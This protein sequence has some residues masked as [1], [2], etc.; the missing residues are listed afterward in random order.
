MTRNNVCSWVMVR[1][2]MESHSFFICFFKKKTKNTELQANCARNVQQNSGEGRA[3]MVKFL[4]VIPAK[5]R[6][7]LMYIA[8]YVNEDSWIAKE[9]ES[10]P[11]PAN[12]TEQGRRNYAVINS[13]RLVKSWKLQQAVKSHAAQV[14]RWQQDPNKPCFPPH[15]SIISVIIIVFAV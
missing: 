13:D 3:I 14:C 7:L 11:H 15:W 9:E 12:K 10:R 1:H 4:K 8:I 6:A 5:A 2:W